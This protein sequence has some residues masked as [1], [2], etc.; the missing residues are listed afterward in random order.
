MTDFIVCST[1]FILAALETFFDA[2]CGLG[3]A[4][5]LPQRCLRRGVG[6]INIHLH[7]LL[8]VSGAVA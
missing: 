2:L 4:G 3:Y 1:G 6:Q 7:D 5:T 8:V